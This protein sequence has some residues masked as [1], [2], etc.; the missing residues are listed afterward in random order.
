MKS[1]SSLDRHF[2][3]ITGLLVFALG[4]PA[5]YSVI[6]EPLKADARLDM[7][8][9]S[10][11]NT[12]VSSQRQPAAVILTEET[13]AHTAL[14]TGFSKSL[15]VDVPCENKDI[16]ELQVSH[17][18]LLGTSCGQLG[19]EVSVQNISNGFT[20]EVIGL[21]DAK[22]T[23][24]FID[25]KEGENH[26]KITRKDSEGKIEEQLIHVKRLPASISDEAPASIEVQK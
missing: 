2:L 12:K 1:S 25:L 7:H 24:D 4:A 19:V 18:R 20:A 6:K 14:K 11:D 10:L 15:S 9:V 3:T 22:Y 23:T 16:G 21:K 8:G 5:L 13:H 17:L 26:L